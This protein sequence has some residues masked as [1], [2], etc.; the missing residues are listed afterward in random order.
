MLLSMTTSQSARPA[1]HRPCG[2]RG[3]GDEG[4][5]PTPSLWAPSCPGRGLSSGSLRVVTKSDLPWVLEIRGELSLSW[6]GG[7]SCPPSQ[8]PG[9]GGL[10]TP[11]LPG[12]GR[13]G[14]S[15]EPVW[16]GQ[17]PSPG[18]GGACAPRRQKD[19]GGQGGPGGWALA[20]RAWG[21]LLL[22]SG[23]QVG[24]PPFLAVSRKHFPHL[25]LGPSPSCS[26][27]GG[28]EG[29][30]LLAGS[31]GS[32]QRAGLRVSEKGGRQQA[33]GGRGP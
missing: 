27:G 32:P 31:L 26:G 8:T 22:P 2:A 23:H 21:F 1:G 7:Q 24:R 15:L 10:S 9:A 13:F 18:E 11:A 12:A 33:P 25:P 4:Q 29:T 28:E 3:S 30:H 14:A 19:A 5:A 16:G 17:A 6:L 20:G